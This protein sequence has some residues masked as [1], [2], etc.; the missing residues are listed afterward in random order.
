MHKVTIYIEL[1]TVK[2]VLY[3]LY[4]YC[5]EA[6]SNVRLCEELSWHA[7]FSICEPNVTR[8]EYTGDQFTVVVVH[9]SL[10]YENFAFYYRFSDAT[11]KLSFSDA[12]IPSINSFGVDILYSLF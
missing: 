5:I 9:W 12:A 1:E 2:C 7:R 11:A 4:I 6:T 8:T 10:R 3:I